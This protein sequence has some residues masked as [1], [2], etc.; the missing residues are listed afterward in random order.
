MPESVNEERIFRYLLD[1]LTD[2]ERREIEERYFKDDEYFDLLCA[3]ED[4]LIA[5]YLDERLLDRDRRRFEELYGSGSQRRKV[6]ATSRLRRFARQSPAAEK[7]RSPETGRFRLGD[8]FWFVLVPD[9]RGAGGRG[10]REQSSIEVPKDTPEIGLQL[11][12]DEIEDYA[13]Y[14]AQLKPSRSD[15]VVWR[16]SE[17]QLDVVEQGKLLR[18]RLPSDALKDGEYVL[19]VNGIRPNGEAVELDAYT[20]SFRRS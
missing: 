14:E 18:L 3:V 8:F 6:E 7:E 11:D 20:F 13:S 2:E 10:A 15:D 4:D 19:F 1:D 5:A 16:K 12:I 17:C 9:A